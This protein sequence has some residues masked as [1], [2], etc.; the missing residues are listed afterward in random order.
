VTGGNGADIFVLWAGDGTDTFTDFKPG[1]DR[2]GLTSN[3]PNALKYTDLVFQGSSIYFK[4]VQGELLA[5]LTAVNTATLTA[6]N[7]ISY[8]G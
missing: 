3:G 6:S 1:T 4:S 8:P 2:I 7:F 5:T